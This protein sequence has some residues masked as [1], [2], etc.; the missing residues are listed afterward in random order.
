M[1]DLW[2]L[3]TDF[4]IL[5]SLRPCWDL[6]LRKW[7]AEAE[8]CVCSLFSLICGIELKPKI[9]LNILTITTLFLKEEHKSLTH[10]QMKVSESDLC[11][12]AWPHRHWFFLVAVPL[13]HI[14]IAHI[15]TLLEIILL[16]KTIIPASGQAR[17]W[18]SVIN[19][20]Q[21]SCMP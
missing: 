21:L 1:T 15:V 9:Y 5:H 18:T 10:A 19:Q 8:K 3:I 2:L 14:N 17:F 7:C 20:F 16:S 6:L 11:I 4:G 12:H 13:S